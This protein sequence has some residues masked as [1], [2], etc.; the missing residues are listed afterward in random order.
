LRAVT[1][2]GLNTNKPYIKFT[3]PRVP[4][5]SANQQRNCGG[6]KK[7]TARWRFVMDALSENKTKAGGRLYFL[8]KLNVDTSIQSSFASEPEKEPNVP[9]RTI[10]SYNS[11]LFIL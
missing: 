2:R 1:L 8:S 6:W 10:Y 4:S 7:I 5:H 9:R 11:L 3:P